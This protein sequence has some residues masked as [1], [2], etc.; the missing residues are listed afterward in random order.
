M[1]LFIFYDF[2]ALLSQTGVMGL[3]VIVAFLEA[4]SPNALVTH[5][6]GRLAG[7][8]GSQRLWRGVGRWLLRLGG[9][10]CVLHYN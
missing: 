7:T 5:V 9:L 3:D 2:E 1:Q 6:L 8:A 10:P 4:E